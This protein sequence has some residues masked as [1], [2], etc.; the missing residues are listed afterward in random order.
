M[1]G[2]Y[3]RYLGTAPLGGL[4]VL[5]KIYANPS[6]NHTNCVGYSNLFV[7]LARTVGVPVSHI[8]IKGHVIVA[9]YF[10]KSKNWK[11]VLIEPQWSS[12][13]LKHTDNHYNYKHFN[14]TDNKGKIVQV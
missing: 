6:G 8:E 7:S 11:E 12:S 3:T 1:G 9:A 10:Y 5:K 4:T 13:Y 14:I 2:T